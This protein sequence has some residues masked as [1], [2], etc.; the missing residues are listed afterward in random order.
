MYHGSVAHLRPLPP[1]ALSVY[2]YP[3][4]FRARFYFDRDPPPCHR[5]AIRRAPPPPRPEPPP[6]I[7]LPP[8]HH[9]LPPPAPM[10]C[11][12]TEQAKTRRR[13][14][15]HARARNLLVC[16]AGPGGGPGSEVRPVH[17]ALRGVVT[18]GVV[19]SGAVIPYRCRGWPRR[20]EE[21]WGPAPHPT[22][23]HR[24]KSAPRR[25]LPAFFY[26]FN[27][28]VVALCCC[29]AGS[30]RGPIIG[31]ASCVGAPRPRLLSAAASLSAP[32]PSPPPR[33]G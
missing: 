5:C 10:R 31:R 9:P 2:P 7:R 18:S 20:A 22:A 11:T 28:A 17:V 24:P 13:G 4:S 1:L 12:V 32:P 30:R 8:P 14:L 15:L 26:G 6:H 29:A 27:K 19:T 21:A 16:R 3:S 25:R 23:G 33:D